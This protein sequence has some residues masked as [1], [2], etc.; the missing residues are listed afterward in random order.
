MI[1]VKISSMEIKKQLLF[2]SIILVVTII[3]FGV[4]DFDLYVQDLFYNFKEQTWILD[5][6]L[7]PW[8]F[9]FYDGIKKLLITIALVFLILI[10]FLKK[11]ERI[12]KYQ[13]GILIIVLSSILIPL[14]I[15]GLKKSTNM[16]CPKNEIQYLGNL[17]RTAVWEKYS[18]PYRS[19]KH[20]SCWPAGHASGGFVL[21]SFFFLFTTKKNKIMALFVALTIG[22]SMGIYKM[23]IGDHY[24][25]HT[26]ITM[27]ISWICILVIHKV[28]SK[29]ID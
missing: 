23:L 22:W 6:D 25:S 21:L 10:L 4:T 15:G 16:P 20:I 18:E 19:M 14:F 11:N 1:R 13:K 29:E 5:R 24:L 7:Q 26:I 9:I 2:T 27:I 8:K 17:P 3:V 12:K 28:I